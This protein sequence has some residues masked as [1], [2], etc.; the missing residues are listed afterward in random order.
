MRAA[1]FEAV[2]SITVREAPVPDPGPGEVRLRVV[3][4][5]ICGSD[6][7]VY[8]TGALAGPDVVLGHEISA[9]VDLDPA[10]RWA[11]G[12]RVVPFPSRGCGTCL[13]CREGKPRYC[14]Q[15]PYGRWGGFAEF[16]CYPASNLIPIPDHLDD[17]AAAAAEPLGVSLRAVEIA[18][19]RPGDLA[20]VSGLG[21]IGL[22]AVAGL[23][24][25]GCRV[26]GS[27]PREDRRTLGLDMGCEAVFDPTEEDPF[28]AMLS[29][30]L[31][32]PRL[33]FEC[34]GAPDSLQHVIDACGPEG[35]IAIL[36][37]PMGPVLLLRM[38]VREQRAFSIAGPSMGSMQRALELLGERPQTAKVITN[39]V[40]LEEIGAAFERLVAG[41]GGVKVLVAPDGA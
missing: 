24:T 3:N 11:G 19:P 26:I 15:P 34:S 32:G 27:D 4:C 21:S 10:G 36:G 5:G 37:I 28:D 39:T 12:T 20:Y 7:S 29:F 14:A 23:V 2:R 30:D 8:K 17:A 22:F 13:W 35:T 6:L 18:G 9:F 31:H 25:A 1:F 41:D 16:T 33:A 40:P 38:A